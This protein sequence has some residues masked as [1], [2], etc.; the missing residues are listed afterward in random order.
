[1]SIDISVINDTIVLSVMHMMHRYIGGI[2]MMKQNDFVNKLKE[3]YHDVALSL[4]IDY[5]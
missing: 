5:K 2:N 4:V 1:M 3:I